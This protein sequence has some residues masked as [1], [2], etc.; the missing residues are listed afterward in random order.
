M[1]RRSIMVVVARIIGQR[2]MYFSSLFAQEWVS[3]MA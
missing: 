3:Q 2:G 1:M